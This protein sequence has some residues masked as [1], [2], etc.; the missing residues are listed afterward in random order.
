LEAF[1]A[2]ESDS[3][4]AKVVDRLLNSKEYG[5]RM[6]V[7]WLDLARYSDTHGYQADRYRAMWPWRDWVIKAF[8]ENLP[9]NQFGTWQLAGDLLPHPSQEQILATAFNRLHMQTEEGGSV[10]E[11]FRTAYV[12][13]R[14][15]TMGTTFLAMTFEC[16][17]CHDHKFDP[18]K[19]KEFYQLFSFFNN[20]DE[21]GQTSYFTDSMPV[22]TLLLSTP[23][24]DQQLDALKSR[25]KESEAAASGFRKQTRGAFEEWLESRPKAPEIKGMIASIAFD[26]LKENKVANAVDGGHPAH[27]VEAPELVDS[28]HSGKAAKLNGENGFTLNGIG[29]FS[30][31]DPFSISIWV[32]TATL[33]KRAVII[34][35]SMA[36]LDAGSRGYEMLLEDG[37]PTLGL[38]HMWPGNSLKVRAS[39]PIQTNE[40]VNL[41]MTYDGS[42][43]ASGLNLFVNGEL[44]QT[45]IIRDH[46]W[47]EITYE[48]GD[49]QLTVGYRF[50]DNGFRDGLL[51]DLKVFNRTLTPLEVGEVY[52]NHALERALKSNSLDA[53]ANDLLWDYYLA[54]DSALYQRYLAD[55]HA[56][57]AEQSRLINPIPEV[58]AMREMQKPRPAFIL[59]RG[60]YDAPGDPVTMDTPAAIAAFPEKFP[61]N[62]LGLAEW[63]FS[64]ENPLTAR[65]EVNRLW[66]MMFGRGIVGTSDNFG[67]QGDLP[68]HPELLDWL[69]NDFRENGW[70]IKR[71]LREIA[72]SA[73]YGQSSVASEEALA[74]D[75]E[76]KL[77]SRAPSYRLSAE[78]IR[79]NALAAS[80]LLVKSLGGAPVKPYQP[81]GLWEEKSGAHYERDKGEGLYRRSLYTFW[82]RTSPPPTMIAFDAA[83]RNTCIARRQ[84]TSTPL[85]SLTLLNDP[86]QVE[87]ARWIAERMMK[88]GGT[89]LNAQLRFAFR[90]LT[91]RE[92]SEK[93][94]DVLHRLHDEQSSY[95]AANQQ[96]TLKLLLVGDRANDP[97]LDP[98]KLAANAVVASALLNFDDTLI[99][100]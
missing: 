64:P 91:S 43:R 54:N 76:N 7:D 8:N 49:P 68:T 22:P 31:T 6:A 3:A 80:G 71:M 84:V 95:F 99:K 98:V 40:W 28:G 38:H 34:H 79:D 63:L 18:I 9:Y 21:S 61:R 70:D 90:L 81:E 75:P 86:Q 24:Q 57:R 78:M 65:V 53:P 19:Q 85:Q 51:D 92:P 26:E 60:A 42:S 52:G 5:E 15:D 73:T 13:D 25:I 29:A 47:K 10:E 96:E 27:A 56:V 23:G 12:V 58:M 48:R 30:R 88:E 36:A 72:L 62:R 50:R 37:H 66:Q 32:R 59:K 16:S 4:Q 46:L 89:S 20:I 55:L 74:K 2:D 11:E 17:R 39:N 93:E 83:E 97:K 67:S 100:K 77:L 1:L 44:Q 45:E 41:T 35:R 94:L 33:P 14:V 82:K 87:A 69:A